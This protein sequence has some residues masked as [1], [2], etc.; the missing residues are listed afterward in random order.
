MVHSHFNNPTLLSRIVVTHYFSTLFLNRVNYWKDSLIIWNRK[1]NSRLRAQTITVKR[2]RTPHIS[3]SSWRRTWFDVHTCE[4][5]AYHVAAKRPSEYQR[6]PV[7]EVTNTNVR[8]VHGKHEGI[9]DDCIAR[10]SCTSVMCSVNVQHST[11]SI[12]FVRC[13]VVDSMAV[14]VSSMTAIRYTVPHSGSRWLDLRA[15][16][17]VC[18]VN[19]PLRHPTH[20]SS[21]RSVP[22]CAQLNGH[23]PETCTTVS[24]VW[25][26]P[27][28]RRS[29]PSADGD[30]H[31]RAALPPSH[32]ASFPTSIAPMPLATSVRIEL[33]V[34][35]RRRRC[36]R[37]RPVANP[38]ERPATR[39]ARTEMRLGPW[40][41]RRR[42]FS[43]VAADGCLAS[44][45]AYLATMRCRNA[46]LL[47]FILYC[48]K[49][50]SDWARRKIW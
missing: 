10:C 44:E 9:R 33:F 24:D 17:T 15:V 14:C 23:P 32:V 11:D 21:E 26:P 36:R 46:V 29:A 43:F 31:I 12:R 7:Q 18:L 45:F 20:S 16:R 4:W 39:T 22:E 41:N 34:R 6:N 19:H 38:S 40:P 2:T 47:I 13:V 8:R 49:E 50:T 37:R 1:L 28:G 3:H 48:P 42:W 35:R 30:A 5:N 27:A 25:C